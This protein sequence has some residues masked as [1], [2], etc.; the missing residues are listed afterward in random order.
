MAQSS[1][2]KERFAD[3]QLTRPGLRS[4][5]GQGGGP[6]A[7]DEADERLGGHL[8]QPPTPL[9]V[10]GPILP[11]AIARHDKIV[12]ARGSD[13]FREVMAFNVW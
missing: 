4:E 8:L 9:A 5:E 1:E 7:R 11:V 6:G 2:P 12:C 10:H 3:L 13:D